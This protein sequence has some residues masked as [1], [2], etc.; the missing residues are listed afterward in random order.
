MVTVIV[1]GYNVIH[2]V[3]RFARSLERNLEAAREALLAAC[4]EYRARRGDI[5]RVCVVFDGDETVSCDSAI[6]RGG[7]LAVFTPRQEEADER[8]LE[9]IRAGGRQRRFVVVSND[10]VITNNARAHGAG[11]LSARA[12]AEQLVPRSRPRTTPASSHDEHKVSPKQAQ[13]ITEAYRR[14][15]AE[16][17]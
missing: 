2:A 11:V 3:P 5:A 16:D 13:E 9:L 12:F 7:V 15:L 6:E 14:Y 4:R 1:D 10:T 17:R 8:I